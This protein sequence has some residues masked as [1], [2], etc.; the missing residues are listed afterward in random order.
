M[1]LKI[2]LCYIHIAIDTKGGKITEGVWDKKCGEKLKPYMFMRTNHKVSK[3]YFKTSSNIALTL[4]PKHY[5]NNTNLCTS[6]NI[7]RVFIT[8]T[9]RAN[10]AYH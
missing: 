10:F 9:I 4:E 2:K 8:I 1:F 3:H 6:T 5:I 7:L